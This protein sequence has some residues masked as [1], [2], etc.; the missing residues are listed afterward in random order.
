MRYPNM[1][2]RSPISNLLEDDSPAYWGRHM[3][4]ELVARSDSSRS[5][6]ELNGRLHRLRVEQWCKHASYAVNGGA[7]LDVAVVLDKSTC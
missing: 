3:L 1:P 5:L 7:G 4:L 6:K 2:Q